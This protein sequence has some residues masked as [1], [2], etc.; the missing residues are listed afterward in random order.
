MMK[1]HA[2]FREPYTNLFYTTSYGTHF[3][4]AILK[5]LMMK[6]FHEYIISIHHR[7][8]MLVTVLF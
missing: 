2:F 3:G 5:I 4:C 1:G 6:L 8:T 7:Q